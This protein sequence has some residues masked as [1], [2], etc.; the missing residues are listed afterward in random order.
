LTTSVGV[1]LMPSPRA[2]A[3]RAV[4]G[5]RTSGLAKQASHA[6]RSTPE[7]SAIRPMNAESWSPLFSR[8]WFQNTASWNCQ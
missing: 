1:E 5:A 6:V 2:A 7:A 8:P 3:V 4:T